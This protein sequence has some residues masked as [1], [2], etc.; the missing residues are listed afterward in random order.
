MRV[1]IAKSWYQVERLLRDG[2]EI[3]DGRIF[4]NEEIIGTITEK[5]WKKGRRYLNTEQETIKGKIHDN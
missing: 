4:G 2:V 5:E 3:A 1:L